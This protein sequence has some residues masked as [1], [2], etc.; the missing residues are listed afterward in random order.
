MRPRIAQLLALAICVALLYGATRFTPGID[1]GRRVL[2]ILGTEDVVQ[3]AP[4]DYAFAI[5]AFGAFRSLIVNIAFIRA[6]TF[7]EQGRYYDAMQLAEWIC[8]LQPRFP[9]VWAFQSWNMAWNIS[10]TTFT[11]QE[12]WKWVYNGVKLLRDEGIPKNPRAVNLYKQLAWIYNNKMSETTDDFHWDYKRY[13]A[14]HM[15]L[16]L[17][18]RSH[19]MRAFRP[20]ADFEPVAIDL[21]EDPLAA[22]ARDIAVGYAERRQAEDDRPHRTTRSAEEIIA[23]IEARRPTGPTRTET[24][25]ARRAAFDYIS[26]IAN[27]PRTLAA[28]HEQYPETREMLSRLRGLGVAITE[29]T[30]SE[31]TYWYEGRLAETFFARYRQLADGLSL[32]DTIARG[33]APD[34]QAEVLERFDEIV[35]VRAGNPAGQALVRY[36]QRRVLSE[37]YKLDPDLMLYIIENFGPVDW[38]SVDAHSLYWAVTALRRA[39]ADVGAFQTDRVNTARIM[40][41]SL[42]NLFHRNRMRFEPQPEDVSRSY[43]FL[44]RDP[45]FIEPMHRA[46]VNYGPLLDPDPGDAGG[47]GDIFRTGHINF[48][49]E[50]VQMLYFSGRT[51]EAAHYYEYLRTNYGR[52]R[53]STALDLQYT[54]PLHDFVMSIM[55]AGIDTPRATEGIIRDLLT[56]AYDYLAD[57]DVTRYNEYVLKARELHAQYMSE[58]AEFRTDRVDLLPFDDIQIDMLREWF[59]YPAASANEVI[60][61]ARMWRVAPPRLKQWV[62]DDL[63]PQLRYECELSGFDVAKA[64]T[65]PPGMVEFRVAHPRRDVERRERTAETPAQPPGGG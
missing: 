11:P 7:K 9:S 36:L 51:A 22:R 41:F 38:R 23:E 27:A 48:L 60:H 54:L 57:E 35:G 33:A 4:P 55:Y 37:V 47:A 12:R 49:Q 58:K 45:D 50:V 5:Q 18:P 17:G 8:R 16:V 2:N 46:F 15:H 24:E 43:I 52:R 6:E 31:D 13:W 56:Q 10:V 62:Y 63:L 28:L 25:I 65:E 61:K 14:W 32:R 59:S 21:A 44:A 40:F 26:T 19:W 39:E 30:L 1:A 42:R 64:F 3:N 29:D 34:P 53:D 20:P